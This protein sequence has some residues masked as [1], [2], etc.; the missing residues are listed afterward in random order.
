MAKSPTGIATRNL[1]LRPAQLAPMSCDGGNRDGN[2]YSRPLLLSSRPTSS[3]K[4]I[5]RDGVEIAEYSEGT[6]GEAGEAVRAGAR[7]KGAEQVSWLRSEDRALAI[8]S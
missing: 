1:R 5:S 8:A 3:E 6:V 7:G 4:S 2:G